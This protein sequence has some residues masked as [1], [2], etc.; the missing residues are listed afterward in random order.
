MGDDGH[1][2]GLQRAGDVEKARE[3]VRALVKELVKRGANFVIPVDAEPVR[4]SDSLPICFDWLIW[5]MIKDK[6]I[7][8]FIDLKVEYYD[9]GMENRDATNDQVT[10]DAANRPAASTFFI[11][12]RSDNQD[13]WEGR[14][15]EV[16]VFS[17]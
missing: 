13:N 10:I 6:L 2:L 7:L 15:D 1:A 11:G 9:L 14:L 16:A 17:K 3:L 4:K 5:K 8:P 12:G